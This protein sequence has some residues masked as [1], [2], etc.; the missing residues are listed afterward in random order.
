LRSV[1]FV[2]EARDLL[3]PLQAPRRGNA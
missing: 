2:G 3:L 1:R